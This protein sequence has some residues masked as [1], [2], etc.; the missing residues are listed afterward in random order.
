MSK[1]THSQSFQSPK[2]GR[3]QKRRMAPIPRNTASRFIVSP[4]IRSD[5]KVTDYYYPSTAVTSTGTVINLLANLTAGTGY[6]NNFVGRQLTPIGLDFRYEVI[7]AQSN[8]L[9]GADLSN[10]TRVMIVQWDD[11][12]TPVVGS[13]LQAPSTNMMS[14]ISLTNYDN[15][16]VLHDKLY[17]TWITAYDVTS[18]YANSNSHC[19]RKYIKGHR[20]NPVMWNSTAVDPQKGGLYA[21]LISDSSVTPN[22]FVTFTCRIT[23]NDM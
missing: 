17:T 20:M 7:G 6:F 12:L 3:V 9:A 4:S 15:I 10:I 21:I 22:P 1:R 23:F 5:P 16:T 11:S 18:S 14:P 13:I 19:R 8:A 2:K